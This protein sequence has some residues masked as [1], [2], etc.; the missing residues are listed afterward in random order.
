MAE[1]SVSIDV[2]FP[3]MTLFF[4]LYSPSYLSSIIAK[5]EKLLLWQIHVCIRQKTVYDVGV[6][7][8]QVC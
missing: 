8:S 7:W 6:G 2:H 1:Y 5:K 3:E 4:H